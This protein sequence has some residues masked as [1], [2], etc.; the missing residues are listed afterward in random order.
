[1][2]TNNIMQ[3]DVDVILI[4]KMSFIGTMHKIFG[5]LGVIGGIATCFGIIT[6]VIGIPYILASVKLFKSGSAFS[7]AAYSSDG[8]FLKDALMNLAACWFFSLIML[9]ITIV[10]YI[11]IVAV[12][13]A[14]VGASY[15]Y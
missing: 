5:V 2:E 9:A 12:I 11:V 6:A 10:F 13:I 7:Y 3:V 14:T 1:M 4:K 8:K 15:N